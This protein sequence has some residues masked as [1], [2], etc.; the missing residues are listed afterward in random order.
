LD[1]NSNLVNLPFFIF[2][3]FKFLGPFFIGK[4]R[5]YIKSF[6]K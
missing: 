2:L 4:N 1:L 6:F 3:N 5:S